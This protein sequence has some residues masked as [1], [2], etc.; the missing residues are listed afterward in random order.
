MFTCPPYYG[1]QVHIPLQ[2]RSL[3]REKMVEKENAPSTASTELNKAEERR[4]QLEEYLRAKR[5]K[6]YVFLQ[7]PGGWH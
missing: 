5:E 7:L 4:R 6:K 3:F 1:D 2:R